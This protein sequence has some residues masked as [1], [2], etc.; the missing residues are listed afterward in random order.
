MIH[1]EFVGE[2]NKESEELFLKCLKEYVVDFMEQSALRNL[3]LEY[4]LWGEKNIKF[5]LR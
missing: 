1:I 3:K 5:H 2:K 4:I